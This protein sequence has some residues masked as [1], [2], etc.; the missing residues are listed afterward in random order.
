MFESN[1]MQELMNHYH[2]NKLSHAFLVETNDQEKCLH[3]LLE[4]LSF[5]NKTGDEKEDYKLS[6]LIE[7]ESL[8]SLMIIRPD[9]INIKK[10]QILDLK[11]FF[12]TRPTF[13]KYNMYIIMASENLNASSANTMLKFLEEPEEGIL[14][15]FL[16]NNKENIIDTIKS[17]CQIVI[18]YYD[19]ADTNSIPKVWQAIA[20][21]YIKEY[22]IVADEA[23]LYNKNVIVPLVHDKKECFYLLQ[24]IFNIYSNLY[25]NKV[26]NQEILADFE[27]L[28]FLLKKDVNYFL[29]QMKYISKLIEDLN[30]NVNI[31]LLL[32]RFVLESR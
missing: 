14:G 2:E 16:T 32:D 4:F 26:A 7:N 21:N 17:R 18:D 27:S 19:I 8:P 30:F 1:G 12:Q 22:E 24:T 11:R 31:S 29:M 23:L 28:S 13:S 9:G 15:F 10:E 6:Q 5:I 20:V 25:L 3:N